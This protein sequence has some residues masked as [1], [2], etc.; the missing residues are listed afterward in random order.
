MERQA[1]GPAP[2]CLVRAHPARQSPKAHRDHEK[3]PGQQP[4]PVRQN[5][6]E[7]GAGHD[8]AKAAS[9]S[10]QVLPAKERASQDREGEQAKARSGSMSE[11][12]QVGEADKDGA[13]GDP[14]PE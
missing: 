1:L 12:Q 13:D 9:I 5:Q 2:G 8:E 3:S 14:E 4:R 7:D 11:E 10:Q 6:G